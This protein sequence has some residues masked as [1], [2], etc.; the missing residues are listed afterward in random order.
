[1]EIG[2]SSPRPVLEKPSLS[3]TALRA[4]SA[5][6]LESFGSTLPPEVKDVLKNTHGKPTVEISFS[7]EYRLRHVVP[8]IFDSGFLDETDLNLWGKAYKL[9]VIY[10]QL[11]HEY[12]NIDPSP[13]RGYCMRRNFADK[14]ELLGAHPTGQRLSSSAT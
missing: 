6:Q 12:G 11:K 7:G 1:V 8:F 2:Y 13:I 3:L 14:T 4:L 9:V 10:R 5:K